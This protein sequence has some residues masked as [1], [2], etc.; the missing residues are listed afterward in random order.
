MS[1]CVCVCFQERSSSSSSGYSS[2]SSISTSLEGYSKPPAGALGDRM[3]AMKQAFQVLI[4]NFTLHIHQS[5]VRW[6]IS[7][8]S[9][10]T[11]T[12]LILEAF[13]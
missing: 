5:R 12:Q 8:L 3:N 9:P 7:N 13:G 4:Q 11:A 2:T 1:L 10:H 6:T